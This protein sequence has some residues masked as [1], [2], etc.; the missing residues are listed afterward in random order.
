MQDRTGTSDRETEAG[1]DPGV[2]DP[3]DRQRNKELVER[4][5]KTRLYRDYEQA[6]EAATGLPLTLR[7]VESFRFALRDHSKENEFCVLM[8]GTNRSCSA[9]LAMQEQLEKEAQVEP[10]TLR[11]FAGMCDTAVPIRVGENLIAFLQTGQVLLHEPSREE[12]TEITRKLI[13]WGAEVDLKKL[14]EA[15]FQTRVLDEEQYR[16]FVK[17]LATFAEHL[18]VVSNSIVM[19]QQEVEPHVVARARRYI[20][21]HYHR[22]LSLGEAAGA[23]NASAHYFCKMFKKA[24]GMTFTEYLT[25]IRIEK[26]KHLLHN[27]NRRISEVAFEVGFESLSQFNRAFKRMA[28]MT[29]TAFRETLPHWEVSRRAV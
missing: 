20:I 29:P 27:P 26:A 28:G 6:F 12:F 7:P 9:C 2:A 1:I 19:R 3:G 24:T 4:L 11:C 22:P 5:R 16:A 10:K 18:S 25:R 8:A 15:Y 23:V 13:A 21:E 17:L 14:E